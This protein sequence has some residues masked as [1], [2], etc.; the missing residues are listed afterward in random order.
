VLVRERVE[1]SEARAGH[2]VLDAGATEP[3]SQQPPEP[4]VV[5]GS[6]REVGVS[7]FGRQR[8]P[9]AVYAMQRRLAEAGASGNHR[10]GTVWIRR[11]GLKRVEFTGLQDRQRR[12]GGV[13]VVHEDDARPTQELS[14]LR[15]VDLPRHIREARPAVHDRTGD[16]EAYAG[17][18]VRTD[19]SI[20][21]E[22]C[23][24]GLRVRHVERAVRAEKDRMRALRGRFEQT[25]PSRRAADIAREPQRLV[26]AAIHFAIDIT[27]ILL[28][29]EPRSQV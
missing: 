27:I 14:E 25:Q 13:Q 11:A 7:G 3:G 20:A 28:H 24:Q 17:N 29:L 6:W 22:G 18:G 1:V 12:G 16:A 4:D 26:H 15:C 10:Q 9:S 5:V 19:T 2:D 21:Q 8:N 23:Q